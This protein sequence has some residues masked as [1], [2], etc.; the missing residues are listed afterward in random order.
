MNM[1]TG[2]SMTATA[3]AARAD[4]NSEV[5]ASDFGMPVGGDYSAGSAYFELDLT[6]C[7]AEP[8]VGYASSYTEGSATL[9]G[10]VFHCDTAHGA[11]LVMTRD[12]AR[13]A[14]WVCAKSGKNGVDLLEDAA[15]ED[16]AVQ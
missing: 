2:K 10:V 11:D 14:A 8:D 4:W 16:G 5:Y 12:E 1:H 9:I 13:T 6:R 3:L 7:G 15:F